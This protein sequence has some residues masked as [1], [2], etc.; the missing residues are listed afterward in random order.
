M[1]L[2]LEKR[3]AKLLCFL[4]LLRIKKLSVCKVTC[5]GNLTR[6]NHKGLG[7]ESVHHTNL[8]SSGKIE[9]SG[10]QIRKFA[11]ATVL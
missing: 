9:L 7:S 4:D 6:A 1:L 5:S 3:K 11:K 10:F 2:T 8:T